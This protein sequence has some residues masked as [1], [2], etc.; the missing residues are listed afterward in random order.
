MLY[1]PGTQGL[2]SYCEPSFKVR[3]YAHD[4]VHHDN[5]SPAWKRNNDAF[6]LEVLLINISL[7]SL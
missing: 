4:M 5:S 3:I 7:V 2:V 6:S 1:R